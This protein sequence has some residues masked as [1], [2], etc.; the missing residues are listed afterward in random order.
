MSEQRIKLL[1]KQMEFMKSTASDVLYSGAAGAG[2]TRVLCYKARDLALQPNFPVGLFR[3]RRTDLRATTLRTMLYP[4]ADLPPVLAA[5][6]Y[7]HKKDESIIEL[8]GGGFIFYGGFDDELKLGSLNLG[9]V[10]IDEGIELEED[11]WVMLQT[12][13]RNKA[14][15][16]RQSFCATNPGTPS[17]FLYN[18]FYEGGLPGAHCIETNTYDNVF[19]PQ[20]YISRMDR[21]TGTAHKRL[22]E[23]Q[24]VAHQGLIFGGL[25][26]EKRE[27]QWDRLV[28]GVD[29]GFHHP[30]ALLIGVSNYNPPHVLK[31]IVGAE[32]TEEKFASEISEVVPKDV[33]NV[34]VDPSAP[35]LIECIKNEGFNAE[36]AD[37]D[38][39]AGISKVIQVQ[40]TVSPDCS[41]MRKHCNSYRWNPNRDDKPIKEN[42]HG[43]DAL[44]YALYS[45]SQI[46]VLTKSDK[47]ALSILSGAKIYD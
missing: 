36:S 34:W 29:A 6:T 21:L 14:G 11:E 43:P 33:D 22:V 23:G 9:A 40:P 3:K 25:Q 12:R 16:L 28:L 44:R 10:L 30:H 15:K 35:S 1:P 42:D 13:M 38:V 19:L 20:D 32:W 26:F 5:G 17:H 37:N 4:D 31:E 8:P 7:K 41:V 39:L 2:K 46:K 47:N 45:D 18:Y 24:W 27:E